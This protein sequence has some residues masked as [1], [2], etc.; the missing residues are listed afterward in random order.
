MKKLHAILITLPLSC[1]TLN[2]M[3]AATW[4]DNRYAHTWGPEKNQYKIG[5][6]HIFD[7]GAGILAGAF[8]DVGQD[9]DQM[10]STFQEYEGWYPWKLDDQWSITTGGL[11]DIDNA[12]TKLSPYVSLDYKPNTVIS[13]STRYRYN[14]MTHKERDYNGNMD[15]NDSHQIDLYL[16]YQATEKLWL[17]LNPEFFINTGDYYAANAKKTHWEP[18]IVAR[19][20]VN[21]QWMPYTEV[22]WLDK[23]HNNDNQVRLRIGVRYYF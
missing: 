23:D 7:N 20:R 3:A 19:Y 18:S 17:Q 1:F 8:Y 2:A 12:G 22:A 10:R 15:Y 6:G 5:I 16:N 14:H 21:K 13:F 9:F 4:V 11:T